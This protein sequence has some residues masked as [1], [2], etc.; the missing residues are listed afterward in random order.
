M[1]EWICDDRADVLK[2]IEKINAMTEEE[3][4]AYI[5]EYEKSIRNENEKAS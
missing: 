4:R 3:K 1:S 2:L 5:E